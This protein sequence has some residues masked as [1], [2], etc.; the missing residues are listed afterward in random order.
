MTKIRVLLLIVAL[1]PCYTFG[2][3]DFIA[4]ALVSIPGG[5][6]LMGDN[7][8]IDVK[9]KHW[10]QHKVS[11]KTFLLSK[12]EVTVKEFKAFVTDTNYQTSNE[13]WQWSGDSSP[14]EKK[15]GNWS[16]A[17]NAPSD[18]HP[19][20]CISYI[21]ALAYVT[22][23]SEKTGYQ[24]R[25]PSEAEWEYAARAGSTTNYFFGDDISQLCDFAN[26]FDQ[27]SEKAFN[28]DLGVTWKGVN[29]D[30][31]AEY[32]SI[33]GQYKPN[34]FGLY[35]MIGN[36]GEFVSDCEHR[37][38]I[39]APIDGSAWLE[40]CYDGRWLGFISVSADH[41]MFIHRGGSYGY[42]AWAMSLYVR[43]HLGKNNTSSLGEGFRIALDSSVKNNKLLVQPLASTQIFIKEHSQ[44]QKIKVL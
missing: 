4:P 21:D 5:D 30:D 18:F 41:D 10:P 33:V 34:A 24:F 15:E 3:S 36:V 38:Y 22:W 2:A 14:L 43:N 39:N 8:E 20:M 16:S 11:V 29:C 25:L 32:T 44:A 6:F 35:D 26:V 40:D 1:T 17:L 13:C 19:V 28:R 37:D 23:L 27:S 9:V 31:N 42:P 7:Q 12:Y